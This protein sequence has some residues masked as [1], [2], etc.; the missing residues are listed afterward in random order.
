MIPTLL[1]ANRGEIAIR[2]ARTAAAMGVRTV[3]VH[4]ADDAGSLHLRHADQAIAL[5]GQGASAYLDIEALI[6]V[7]RDEGCDAVHPGYGFL[8]E[9]AAFAE[10]CREAGLIFVGPDPET[11]ALLGDKVSARALAV[12]AGVPVAAGSGPLATAAEVRA[13]LAAQG[14]APVLLKAVPRRPIRAGARRGRGRSPLRSPC[15]RPEGAGWPR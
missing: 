14:G 2:V 15:A 6:A 9:S 1:I 13:F 12:R 4:S 5:P 11:L 10:A 3:A 7:A 8:S